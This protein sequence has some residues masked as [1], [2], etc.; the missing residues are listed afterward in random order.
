MGEW[1]IEILTTPAQA[2][3]Y[4]PLTGNCPDLHEV[5][6]TCGLGRFLYPYPCV[7]YNPQSQS[8]NLKR[9]V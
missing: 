3:A 7:G 4:H 6:Q 9:R 5:E 8:E 1:G 2:G